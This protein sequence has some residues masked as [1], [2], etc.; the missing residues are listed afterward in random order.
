MGLCN[1]PSM[2]RHYTN[3]QP[4]IMSYQSTATI[5]VGVWS[6]KAGTDV[7]STV[8]LTSAGDDSSGFSNEFCVNKADAISEKVADLLRGSSARD[9][10][11]RRSLI[12]QRIPVYMREVF[13]DSAGM[14]ATLGEVSFSRDEGKRDAYLAEVEDSG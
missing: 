14:T 13:E 12:E 7:R 9:R 10:R 1:P 11:S 5:Y 6:N 2:G 8:I 4:N 3:H